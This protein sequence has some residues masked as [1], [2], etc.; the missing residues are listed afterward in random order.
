MPTTRLLTWPEFTA[1]PPAQQRVWDALW[2]GESIGRVAINVTPGNETVQYAREHFTFPLDDDGDK[3]ECYHDGWRR[4]L[5]D[6]LY[7]FA[8]QRLLPGDYCPAIAVPRPVHGQSQG[9]ADLFGCRVEEQPDGNFFPF[10]LPADPARIDEV[11]PRPLQTSRYWQA[12]EWLHYARAATQ[13]ALPFRNPVMTG[14]LDTANYLL[15]STTLLEWV[16][17]EPEVL[18]RLLAKTTD[19]IIRMLRALQKA[20]GG[21]Q[22]SITVNCARGGF[23]LC[24]ELR[25]IVSAEIYREFEAPYLRQIGEQLGPFAIHSCGSWERTVPIDLA[26]PYLRA[27]NGPSKENDLPTLCANTRGKLLLSI[28]ASV[29]VH[30][31]YLWPDMESYY[32][33]VLT[34][35]PQDQPLEIN[36]N[37]ADLPLW[38]ELHREV[39]GKDYALAAP[40]CE[41]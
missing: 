7:A 41:Q 37:E 30:T 12:V 6:E 16:Y 1:A 5:L 8:A 32:R 25:A 26:N 35:T 28:Y 11:T 33:H 34:V 17:T 14:P 23:G 19:V 3:P 36:V 13:G 24:S 21:I 31:E 27:M 4:F 22:H 2:R 40:A 20:A 15:G 10:P 29:D 18:H 39:V 9:I 38:L